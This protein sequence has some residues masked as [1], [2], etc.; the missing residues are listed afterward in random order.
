MGEAGVAENRKDSAPDR[1]D[2]LRRQAP[3]GTG[4]PVVGLTVLR[5]LPLTPS[6]AQ[7]PGPIHAVA[8][9]SSPDKPLSLL[10]RP[11]KLNLKVPLACV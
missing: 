2:E 3:V 8:H 7:A 1:A 10:A 9:T 11:T 4:V 5:L 6:E